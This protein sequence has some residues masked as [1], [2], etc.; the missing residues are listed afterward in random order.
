[1]DLSFVLDTLSGAERDS[2]KKGSATEADESSAKKKKKSSGEE[3]ASKADKEATRTRKEE[4]GVH[5]GSAQGQGQGQGHGKGV[6]DLSGTF[7]EGHE[8]AA[9]ALVSPPQLAPALARAACSRMS[10]CDMTLTRAI[11]SVSQASQKQHAQH[12][13]AMDEGSAQDTDGAGAEGSRANTAAHAH[14]VLQD[15]LDEAAV[16]IL[17]AE[18]QALADKV[19][20]EMMYAWNVAHR[21]REEGGAHTAPGHYDAAVAVWRLVRSLS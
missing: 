15:G 13:D 8:H 17:S 7:D 10:T 2:G 3:T 19:L 16:K 9:W 20:E 12:D 21:R 14:N 5:G 18:A 1:M 6:I 4:A 11:G